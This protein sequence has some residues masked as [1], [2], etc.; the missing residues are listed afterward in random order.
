MAKVTRK[1]SSRPNKSQAVVGDSPADAYIAAI[2][3]AQREDVV[4]L[5]ALIRRLR[6]DLPRGMWGKAIIGYGPYKYT[7]RSG[8]EQDGYQLALSSRAQYV[9]FY[10]P[11]AHLY[12]AKLPKADIGKGCIRFKKLSDLDPVVL[13][14]MIR[15]AKRQA[16]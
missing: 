15:T 8:A 14:K 7:Q 13:E 10:Y 2:P 5:D 16:T 1:S 12:S 11:S 4:A 6:P 3:G 9:A